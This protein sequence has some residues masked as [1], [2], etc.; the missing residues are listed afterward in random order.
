MLALVVVALASWAPAQAAP[1]EAVVVLHGLGRN[2]RSMRPL[3]ERLAAAGYEV[4]NLRYPSTELGPEALVANL[5]GQ[6]AACCRQA[7]RLDFVTHSM[8][9]ILV[10]AY[11]AEHPLPT[12][13]RVVMLA[14]PNHGSEYVDVLGSSLFALAMG[15]TAMQLG[16]GPE[17][18]P[19]RL[20][21]PAYEVGVIAGTRS[22]NPTSPFVVAGTSDGTVSVRSTRLAGMADF[23]TVPFS[24]YLMVRSPA[25]ADLV[26]AFLRHGHF[27]E[28]PQLAAP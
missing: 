24:H 11:L 13:G 1:P 10:R 28:R 19:N 15:P 20:P 2:D 4:H 17:S 6:L 7:S 26:I 25:V 9:G 27:A 5:D 18:L 21:P 12:L 14:P 22:I 8:G 23:V 3:A 16:T